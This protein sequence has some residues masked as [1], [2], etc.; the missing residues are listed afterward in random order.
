MKG[1]I[2][3]FCFALFASGLVVFAGCMVGPKYKRPE[4]AADA[5]DSFV[6]AGQHSQDINDLAS[7]DKWWERFADPV[8][9]QLVIQ[10]LENNY[11]LKAAAAR[12][13]QAEAALAQSRGPLWP[14]VS[15][16]INWD[17]S[18]RS[19]NFGGL[20]GGRFS[21]IS[22][23]WTQ[24]ISVVYVLDLWG[25]L[26]R[27]ERA[28]WAD[29]LSAEA[30]GQALIN[31]IIATV[32]NARTNIATLQKQLEIAKANTVSR[33]KTL[34]IVERR[35][36]N[37]LVGP[38]DVRLARENLEAAK[39]VEPS[40]EMSLAM[41]Y[42]ALD[43]LLGRQPGT[44]QPLPHTLGELPDLEPLPVGV[45]AALL[46][47]RP[48]VSAAEFSLRAANERIG[49]SIAEL[50]PNLTL[51]GNLGRNADRWDD[52]WH[53]YS[54]TYSGIISLA[55]PIFRGGQIRAG[56]KASKARYEELA[57]NYASIVLTAM[58]EVEDALVSEQ[59]L[60]QQL[61]HTER[62]LKEVLAAEELSRQRYQ[63][64]VEG[65]LSVLESERRR[66]MA[67][68]QV[69]VLK[70]QLWTTRVN[71]FLA[72]GGDWDY[73]EQEKAVTK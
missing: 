22:T 61:E 48:D 1:Q 32:V 47:R 60:Q 53:K 65:I 59:M 41:A 72:L 66:R 52:V 5:A 19:F 62:Q 38:V 35:Y 24:G 36:S 7:V 50:F 44:S 39:A 34:K 27:S 64:G 3:R 63:W 23:T 71:L 25:K 67:E 11:D 69:A 21:F 58:R 49:A 45:P 46:D 42:H 55:Q 40:I 73:Q 56:I 8:T 43:V 26:R 9:A 30:S 54:E 17:R 18:K 16:S 57:A 70:G 10:V 31:S 51:T 13:L 68:E 14:D 20:G 4:T 12:V 28:A 2:F 33:E 29:M 15:Y 37:G 6:R